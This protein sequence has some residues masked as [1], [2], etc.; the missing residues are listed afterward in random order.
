MAA[1]ELW[2]QSCLFRVKRMKCVTLVHAVQA[3]PLPS[4]VTV[5]KLADP[6]DRGQV[7]EAE[8]V[9][10]DYNRVITSENTMTTE[11]EAVCHQ[12]VQALDL[13]WKWLF[14]P[15]E[16]PEHDTVSSPCVYDAICYCV[17]DLG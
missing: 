14:R 10:D 4:L 13:R 6:K 3:G 1:P 16:L 9:S 5:P 2:H 7:I 11:E 8:A 17:S 15:K 12:L